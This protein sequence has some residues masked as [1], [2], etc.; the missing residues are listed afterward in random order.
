MIENGFGESKRKRAKK[1]RSRVTREGARVPGRKCVRGTHLSPLG[2]THE[3]CSCAYDRA[4]W[5]RIR[6][7]RAHNPAGGVFART[8]VRACEFGHARA[9]WR[10]YDALIRARNKV[11][12][13]IQ[14]LVAMLPVRTTAGGL[15]CLRAGISSPHTDTLSTVLAILNRYYFHLSRRFQDSR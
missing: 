1:Q 11:G 15:R 3:R 5:K 4:T 10:Y 2:H 12:G 13:H 14:P 7:M 6:M 8:C 9:T